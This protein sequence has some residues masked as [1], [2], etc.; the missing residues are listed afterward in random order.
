MAQLETSATGWPN[1]GLHQLG[2]ST[3]DFSN[4]LWVV[5][6]L[7]GSRR[8]AFPA[9]GQAGGRPEKNGA[10][11]QTGSA[12][13]VDWRCF[14]VPSDPVFL[15]G[16]GLRFLAQGQGYWANRKR[17]PACLPPHS[18]GFKAARGAR[19][20]VGLWFYLDASFQ[21]LD[22]WWDAVDSTSDAD[23]QR[24]ERDRQA[25]FALSIQGYPCSH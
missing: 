8:V 15:L 19:L 10:G 7:T 18:P 5:Y 17:F 1:W 11:L 4:W 21:N 6:S 25:L 2:G 24:G 20:P 13:G 3:G 22:R 14:R 16:A 23:D 12:R 9:P